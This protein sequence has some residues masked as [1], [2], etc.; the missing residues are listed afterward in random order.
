MKRSEKKIVKKTKTRRKL[1]I[2]NLQI[3]LFYNLY[4]EKKN[5]SNFVTTIKLK[6]LTNSLPLL[7]FQLFY[8]SLSLT[9]KKEI[10]IVIIEVK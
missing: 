4:I 2:V 9:K 6:K 1:K 7:Y 3:S 8:I 10:E 5:F